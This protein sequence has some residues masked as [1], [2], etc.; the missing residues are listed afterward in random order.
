MSCKKVC[1]LCDNLVSST[2]VV[3]DGPPSALVV[4]LPARSF[5]NGE[6]ACIVIAQSIPATATINAP[7][8]FTIGS[9]ATRYPLVSKCCEPVTVCGV[10]T[11]TKYSTVV[12]TNAT[13][14]TFKMLGEPCCSPSNALE[15]IGG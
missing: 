3:Y 13:G 2:D 12:V 15:S 6:K 9:S 8:S 5:K 11:R 1:K 4:G 7:V 14:G 10:R